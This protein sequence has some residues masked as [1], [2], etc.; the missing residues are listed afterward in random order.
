MNIKFSHNYP[1][2]HGQKQAMLLHVLETRRDNLNAELIEYDTAFDVKH[3]VETIVGICTQTVIGEGRYELPKGNLIH[4]TFLG[5]KMIPFCT[6]R[7]WTPEKLEYYKK[8][9]GNIFMVVIE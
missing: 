3:K 7:R 8:N 2:L 6:I 1:K 4:L 5:D 9:I